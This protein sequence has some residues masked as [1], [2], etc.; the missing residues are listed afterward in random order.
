M[1]YTMQQR[2]QAIIQ[3]CL[4]A[5]ETDPIAI[6]RH[7]AAMDFV[8]IHGPEHHILDGACLLTA[9]RNAGGDICLESALK[10]LMEEGLRMP[11]AMCGLWGVCGSVSSIGAAL[12]LIDGTG[13]LSADSSWGG[14][15]EYSS[16]A[17]ARL[18]AVG[19]PR[20]CK[21][22]AFLSLLQAVDYLNA[23]YPVTL[24][25]PTVRCGFFPENRQCIGERCPFHPGSSRR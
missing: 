19:G 3:A 10:K 11:G 7:V 20:C 13:P 2:G 24:P 1:E 8:R 12:A 22:D 21:R 15:M 16:A 18:A 6:F 17:L 25:A 4:D 14:H 5:R 23:H 9:F